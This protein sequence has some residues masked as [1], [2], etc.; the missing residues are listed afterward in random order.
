GRM[1]SLAWG[2]AGALSAFTAVLV[3][4]SKGVTSGAS[5][6]PSL[7]LRAL[8]GAVV[9]RMTSLPRAMAAGVG[10]GIIEQLLLWNYPRAGFVEVALFGIILV[11]LMLQQRQAGRD[12]EKG[13]WAAVQAWRPIPNELRQV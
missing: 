12:E 9:A 13:S 2:L 4:P 1:S 11:A 8:A 3:F 6:G 5:F 10:L 7:L